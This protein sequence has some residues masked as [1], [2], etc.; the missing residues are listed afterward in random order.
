MLEIDRLS[1]NYGAVRALDDVSLAVQAG[2]VCAVIGANGAGKSTLMKALI[3]LVPV[4]GGRIRLQGQAIESLGTEQRVALGLALSPEGRRLFP[5]LTVRENLVMGAYLRHDRAGIQADIARVYEYF[6]RLKERERSLGRHL[7][8]GEQQMCAIGRALMSRPRLL[9]LD[10][11]SL[12][13]APA[14]TL[15]VARAIRQIS[16]DGTTIILVEQNAR[17]ALRLSHHAVVLETGRLVLSGDS[18]SVASNPQV[19]AAYLGHG[20]ETPSH[21]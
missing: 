1:V 14:V 3:G 9:L 7:S 6:P 19:A 2:G 21:A 13:L 8:G 20:A 5:E 10:E 17:L 11:P 12:G 16:Q 18:A 15:E 4:R